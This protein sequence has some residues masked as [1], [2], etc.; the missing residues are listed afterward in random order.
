MPV[1]K[2]THQA[3][4]GSRRAFLQSGLKNAFLTRELDGE[5][6]LYDPDRDVLHTLNPTARQIWE[7]SDGART[8]EDITEEIAACY[9]VSPD[10]VREHVKRVLNRLNDP[11]HREGDSPQVPV[12]DP[13]DSRRAFLKTGL[14]GAALLPYVAPLIETIYLQDAEAQNSGG[15]PIGNDPPPPDPPPTVTS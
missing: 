13:G 4:D 3:T 11:H 14:K 7:H 2:E 15:S 9:D 8:D 10:A 12:I 6:V 5:L 1:H